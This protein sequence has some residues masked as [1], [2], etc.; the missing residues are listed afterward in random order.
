MDFINGIGL[1]ATHTMNLIG[2]TEYPSVNDM[3]KILIKY[4]EVDARWLLLG[5]GELLSIQKQENE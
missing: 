2:G 1:N 4:P 3:Q 5:K